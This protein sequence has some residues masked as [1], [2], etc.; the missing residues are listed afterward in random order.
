MSDE[1]IKYYITVHQNT[2]EEAQIPQHL[3]LPDGQEDR[4]YK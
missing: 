3:R 1:C 4:T 2:S